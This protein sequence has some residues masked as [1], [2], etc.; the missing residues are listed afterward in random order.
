MTDAVTSHAIAPSVLETELPIAD[1]VVHSRYVKALLV[2]CRERT[3]FLK[4]IENAASARWRSQLLEWEQSSQ[5]PVL[6]VINSMGGDARGGDALAQAL[7]MMAAPPVALVI[8]RAFSAACAVLQ[9]CQLRLATRH[10]RLM[11]HYATGEMNFELR[12]GSDGDWIPEVVGQKR[13]QMESDAL[14]TIASLVRRTG[15]DASTFESLLKLD[16]VLDADEALALGLLDAIV[17]DE[18]IKNANVAAA[19]PPRN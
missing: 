1:G 14:A 5:G 17:S 4:G 15:R 19:F 16:R 11:V 13:V 2:K 18:P 9:G 6:L 7:R 3:L 10:A 12:Y 8:G